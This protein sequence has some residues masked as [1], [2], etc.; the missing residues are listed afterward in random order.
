MQIIHK[1]PSR[2]FMIAG[3]DKMLGAGSLFVINTPT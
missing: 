3:V 2:L 1:V